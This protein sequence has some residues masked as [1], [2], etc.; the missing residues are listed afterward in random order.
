MTQEAKMKILNKI[1]EL[2]ERFDDYDRDIRMEEQLYASIL[3]YA[4]GSISAL[5]A[6]EKGAALYPF[7]RRL[8]YK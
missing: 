4:E 2:E 5:D 6:Y 8:N 3:I 1:A 7:K